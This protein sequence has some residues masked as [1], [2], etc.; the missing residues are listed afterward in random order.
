MVVGMDAILADARRKCVTLRAML[1]QEYGHPT[2]TVRFLTQPE[3]EVVAPKPV[4]LIPERVGLTKS[5]VFS[6]STEVHSFLNLHNRLGHRSPS[7][8]K[9]MCKE[10]RIK[11]KKEWDKYLK[12]FT[13]ASCGTTLLLAGLRISI[14]QLFKHL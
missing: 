6:T 10:L 7:A 12:E 9:E 1:N 3:I 5:E 2:L 4:A 13:C 14:N 8:M 11:W